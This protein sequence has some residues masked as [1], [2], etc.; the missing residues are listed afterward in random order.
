MTPESAKISKIFGDH[1]DS[2]ADEEKSDWLSSEYEG[3]LALDAYQ[4]QDAVIIKAPVAGVKPEDI[5]VSIVDDTVTIKGERKMEEEVSSENYF[6]QECYWGAFSRQIALPPGVDT[7]KANASLKNGI[8]T[9]KIPKEPK[10]KAK[11][12]KISTEI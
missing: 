3:Q 12:L 7:E 4:T 1:N 2:K 11:I 5:E 6:A 8:L 9:I 10:S